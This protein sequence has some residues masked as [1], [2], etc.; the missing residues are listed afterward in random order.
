MKNTTFFNLQSFFHN[1]TNET[2]K[3]QNDR[4]SDAQKKFIKKITH[5]YNPIPEDVYNTTT[6]IIEQINNL[7]LNIK[8]IFE[9]GI[10]FNIFLAGGSIRDL[11]LNNHEKIKDL[12]IIFD[13]NDY[14]HSNEKTF[15]SITLGVIQKFLD[16]DVSINQ[17][18]WEEL[19]VKEK[20]YLVIYELLNKHYKVEKKITLEE[21]K[22]KATLSDSSYAHLL[23]DKL[24]AV[25][26]L[27]KG[28]NPYPFDVLIINTAIENYIKTFSLGICKVYVNFLNPLK[29][30]LISNPFDFF[31]TIHGTSAFIDDGINKTI[32]LDMTSFNSIDTINKII[33]NHFNRIC[34]KYSTYKLEIQS[35]DNEEFISWK[36]KFLNYYSL[37]KSLPPKEEILVEKK[38]KI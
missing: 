9:L 10:K 3:D 12:D 17:Q 6:K 25:I 32:T 20:N 27:E 31:S 37:N 35:G 18:E 26:T 16:I 30:K 29:P 15:K 11:L 36:T 28:E 34:V 23:N 13:F 5:S 4:L 8:P 38:I 24:E 14:A 22:K 1:H 33:E 19:T 2:K 7:I 21:L